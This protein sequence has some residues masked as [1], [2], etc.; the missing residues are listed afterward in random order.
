MIQ[1]ETDVLTPLMD[2]R[3]SSIKSMPCPRCHSSMAPHMDPAHM[4]RDGDLLPRVVGKC[5]EC[6]AQVDPSNGIVIDRGDSRLVEDPLPII[7]PK[8]S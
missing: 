8:S 2:Q 4:Y 7:K 1:G 3:L 6:G 5:Q